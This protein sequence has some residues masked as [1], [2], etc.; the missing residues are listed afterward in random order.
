MHKILVI[1]DEYSIREAIL[2]F[3]EAENFEGIEAENGKI[4]LEKARKHLPDLIICD[5]MM[6][7]LSGYDVLAGL[8]KD[9]IMAT[10]PFIFLT[11][12]ADK[13]DMREG[14]QLGADDYITKPFTYKELMGAIR[15]RLEKKQV[16]E[17]KAQEKLEGLRQSIAVSLPQEL[18]IPLISVSELAKTLED[19][20]EKI[21]PSNILEIAQ[22]IQRDT[23]KL[24]RLINNF[25][26]YAELEIAATDPNRIKQMLS[27]GVI[28][29]K[30]IISEAS[31]QKVKQFSR[32][33]DLHLHLQ[34]AKIKMSKADLEKMIEETVDNACKFSLPGTPVHVS[35][36]L[37]GD[38]YTLQVMD[39]G[40]GMSAD[41]INALGGYIQFERRLY[42]QQGVGLGLSI[43]KR[44]AEFYG[45]KMTIESIENQQTIVIIT[46][47]SIP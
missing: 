32:K 41:K 40:R 44:L 30:D 19:E 35:G 2:E 43:V 37:D 5:V 45:G 22:Q 42:D 46:L 24:Y 29:T 47:P 18:L 34:D 12:K 27:R 7:E 31:L 39:N 1:E 14:M 21:A 6:P 33:G 8:R 38:N 26:L 20:H 28:Y 13:T 15:T 16:I 25:L 36:I 23:Q 9:P 17:K 4:G 11:A 3:L 10:I